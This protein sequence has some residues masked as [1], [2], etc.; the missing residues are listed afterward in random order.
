M[1]QF[2]IK[3]SQP[4]EIT[5][6]SKDN[7][8]VL[9]ASIRSNG[10]IKVGCKRGG[11]GIC[12]IKV[13]DGEVEQ[14]PVSRTVLPLHEEKEGYVLACRTVPQS[15]ITIEDHSAAQMK[16]FDYIGAAI[17]AAKRKK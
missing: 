12:K 16:K 17:Q 9:E 2:Q 15:N 6:S 4:E 10:K 13:V 14:G 5:F 3:V 11:C 8:T 1:N 7:E